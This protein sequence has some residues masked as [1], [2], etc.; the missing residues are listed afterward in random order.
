TVAF[1]RC[2]V[3][4]HDVVFRRIL[5]LP[6]RG[7]GERTF[8]KLQELAEARKLTFVQAAKRVA[9]ADV[10]PKVVT[11]IG[12]LFQFL[13]QLRDSVLTSPTPGEAILAAM[14]QIGYRDFLRKISADGVGAEKRWK[15][16]ELFAGVVDRYFRTRPRTVEQL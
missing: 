11:T 16:V 14:A 1:L 13:D 12:E 2:S 7:L 15:I 3:R 10:E 6:P 8:E 4:P 5:N 9:E